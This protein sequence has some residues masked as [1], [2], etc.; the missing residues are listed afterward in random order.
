M[1]NMPEQA[2]LGRIGGR[3]VSAPTFDEYRIAVGQVRRI[4][5]DGRAEIS[6]KVA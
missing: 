6:V 2:N 4:L 5:P 3:A 1:S